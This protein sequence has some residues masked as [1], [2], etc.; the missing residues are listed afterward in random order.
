LYFVIPSFSKNKAIKIILK[1]DKIKSLINY[2]RE[3]KPVKN[4]KENILFIR[5]KASK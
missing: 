2:F 5:S 3:N 4:S 1:N